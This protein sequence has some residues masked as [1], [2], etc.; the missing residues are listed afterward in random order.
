MRPAVALGRC[1][2]VVARRIAGGRLSANAT[3]VQVWGSLSF[4]LSRVAESLR[5]RVAPWRLGGISEL[6]RHAPELVRALVDCTLEPTATHSYTQLHTAEGYT[7]VE[8]YIKA[9]R[10]PLSSSV[11]EEAA[12]EA[13]PCWVANSASASCRASCRPS[14]RASCRPWR[15]FL[16]ISCRTAAVA[17]LPPVESVE[18][19]VVPLVTNL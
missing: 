5:P 14:C 9:S 7:L 3:R 6:L 18:F 15:S 4:G 11:K 12:W 1:L 2:H 10:K 19:G 16:K 8:S 17:L 13:E